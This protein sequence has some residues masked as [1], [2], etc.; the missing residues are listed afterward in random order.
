MFTLKENVG[1][2]YLMCSIPF[3]QAFTN[4]AT[5]ILFKC[6]VLVRLLDAFICLLYNLFRVLSVDVSI[7]LLLLTRCSWLSRSS[8]R[9]DAL[10]KIKYYYLHVINGVSNTTVLKI[11]GKIITWGIINIVHF[12]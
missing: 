4:Q 11:S 6:S 9:N 3:H 10:S 5:F 2:R 12:V 7:T 1:R 8:D